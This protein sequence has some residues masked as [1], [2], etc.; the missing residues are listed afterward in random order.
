MKYKYIS[1]LLSLSP[2]V[3]SS[4]LAVEPVNTSRYWQQFEASRVTGSY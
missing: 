2:L 3:M 1:L 4:Q